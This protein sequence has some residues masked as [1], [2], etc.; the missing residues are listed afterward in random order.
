VC[1]QARES[2]DTCGDIVCEELSVVRRGRD[3]KARDTT[4]KT[5]GA[6]ECN[7]GQHNTLRPMWPAKA[8]R[9]DAGGVLSP[10][11]DPSPGEPRCA[12]GAAV[13]FYRG[14]GIR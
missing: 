3:G 12:G 9:G 1:E 4:R 5:R 10:W 13:E 7:G 8:L 2:E 14:S 11:G 6:H